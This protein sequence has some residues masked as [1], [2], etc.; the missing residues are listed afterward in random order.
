MGNNVNNNNNKHIIGYRVY[1]TIYYSRNFALIFI[2]STFFRT[3]FNRMYDERRYILHTIT[4][5]KLYSKKK[6]RMRK[7]SFFRKKKL[8]NVPMFVR[9]YVTLT[10]RIRFD[11]FIFLYESI[12]NKLD[13]S[14]LNMIYIV[15]I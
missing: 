4:F 3:R 6:N 11:S 15:K 13:K 8:M 5:K 2:I 7:N 14:N 12:R 1:I 10:V 9:P